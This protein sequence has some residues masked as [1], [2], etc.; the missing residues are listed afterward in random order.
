M[1]QS[2]EVGILANLATMRLIAHSGTYSAPS[3]YHV[4]PGWV[5]T[6]QEKKK[7]T[8]VLKSQRSDSQP[9]FFKTA[10]AA[11]KAVM[12]MGMSNAIVMLNTYKPEQD[13]LL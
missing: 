7:P 12:S 9:R 8:Y 4:G 6:L 11:F 1:S 5:I 13:S 3:I 10:E 2:E